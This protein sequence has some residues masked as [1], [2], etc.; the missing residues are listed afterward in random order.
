MTIKIKDDRIK[1]LE[2]A[3]RD[4]EKALDATREDYMHRPRIVDSAL[5]VVRAALA[6]PSIVVFENKEQL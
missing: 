1:V 5:I 3:L 4:A 2:A 6:T